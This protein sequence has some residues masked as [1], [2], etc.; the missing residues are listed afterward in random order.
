MACDPKVTSTRKSGRKPIL[1]PELVA[2]RLAKNHGNITLV[3]DEFG[4]TRTA[5]YNLIRKRPTLQRIL[6]DAREG[7]LDHAES[8]L[9][10][11]VCEG[12]GWAV[13]FLLKTLGKNRGY[14]ERSEHQHG[15]DGGLGDLI[16]T[17]IQ[18]D[19][20][21]RAMRPEDTVA[22]SGEPGPAGSGGPAPSLAD[23]AAHPVD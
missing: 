20:A 1:N 10:A 22:A 11:K 19:I 15:F 21:E 5:V 9:F 4:V 12:E 23:T 14:V 8:A 17:A 6:S 2:A 13:C 7:C 16:R 18:N 3:A